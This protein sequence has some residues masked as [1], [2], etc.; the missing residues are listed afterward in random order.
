MGRTVNL[1]DYYVVTQIDSFAGLCKETGPFHN[2]V[3]V[4]VHVTFEF[5]SQ[6]VIYVTVKLCLVVLGWAVCWFLFVGGFV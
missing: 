1:W 2:D 4:V 5:S 3:D 6:L